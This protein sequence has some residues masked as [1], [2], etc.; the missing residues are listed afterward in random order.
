[1]QEDV[2]SGDVR[3]LVERNEKTRT[4]KARTVI[5]HSVVYSL[6]HDHGLLVLRNKLMWGF[7]IANNK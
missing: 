2:C 7:D 6:S 5:R 1:M 4:E 3:S